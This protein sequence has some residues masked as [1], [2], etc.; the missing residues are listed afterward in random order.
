[1]WSK[2]VI[3]VLA[4]VLAVA[5]WAPKAL[6]SVALISYAILYALLVREKKVWPTAFIGAFFGLGLHGAGHGWV[7]S[8]LLNYVHSGVFVASLGTTIFVFFLALFTFF[9][10]LIFS[11]TRRA[12]SLSQFSELRIPQH[13]CTK[14]VADILLFAALMTIGEFSRS[15]LFNG[16]TTLS[17]GY[18]F[19]DTPVS[20]WTPVLGVY[21]VG[22]LA[23]CAAALFGNALLGAT[24]VIRWATASVFSVAL[25]FSGSML[26]LIDWVTPHGDLLSYRL[27]QLNVAQDKKFDPAYKFIQIQRLTEIITQTGADLVVTSEMAY[28]V[29]L[30]ALPGHILTRLQR[31]SY[32]KTSNLF[33]G[34]P[35]SA[36]NSDGFNSIIQVSPMHQDLVQYN[37]A[38]LM[39]FGEYSPA[40][41]GWFSQL[42]SIPFK[43]LTSGRSDPQPFAIAQQLNLSSDAIRLTQFVGTMICSEESVGGDLLKWLPQTNLMIDPSNLAWFQNTLAIEQRMQVVKTRAQELGR[44]ILRVV[45]AGISAHID[46]HGKIVNTLSAQND[47]VLVGFLQ[48]MTGSTPYSRYGD[49]AIFLAIF[50][51][52][53]IF[54]ASHCVPGSTV[55]AS[56]GSRLF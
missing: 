27:I 35:T 30:N 49:Q 25:V 9:P 44:P 55:Q 15:I 42:L 41:F 3:A 29:S 12:I 19:A 46:H 11:G 54:I 4:G 39:P 32:E 48:P 31:F 1:M 36:S 37:K 22:W 56:Q 5:G 7:F 23:F 53:L 10:A 13:S 45:N 8:A 20:G 17:L 47:G 38:H 40:G 26:Q 14:S 51:C 2:P 50:L 24:S 28:P 43:N 16:I 33:I 34:I 6:P 52:F 18:A 21:G